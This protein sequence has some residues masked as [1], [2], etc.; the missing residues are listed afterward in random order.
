MS[1]TGDSAAHTAC[2]R[3]MKE[4]RRA[5]E[6]VGRDAWGGPS[7][8]EATSPRRGQG[9]ARPGHGGLLWLLD[10]P[11]R[12]GQV[13]VFLFCQRQIRPGGA[14]VAIGFS[15]MT[16]DAFARPR[17][18]L[19]QPARPPLFLGPQRRPRG[20][21]REAQRAIR[22]PGREGGFGTH[23]TLRKKRCARTSEGLATAASVSG[24]LV[25]PANASQETQNG[26]AHAS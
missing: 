21:V 9:C 4:G 3:G 13:G 7:G 1:A 14:I 8:R 25:R 26:F 18:T 15:V 22:W 10:A 20:A 2:L 11:A 16:W 24:L 17:S 5:A 12:G 6:S 23:P 19:T